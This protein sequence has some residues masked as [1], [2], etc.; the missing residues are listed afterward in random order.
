MPKIHKGKQKENW[1]TGRKN[2]FIVNNDMQN[3][4][5]KIPNLRKTL[6]EL[7]HQSWESVQEA[8]Q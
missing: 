1:E 7:K 4:R 3:E 8:F 2:M 6:L 5:G